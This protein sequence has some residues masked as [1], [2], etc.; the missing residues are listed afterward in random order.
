MKSIE[1]NEFGIADANKE[2]GDKVEVLKAGERFDETVGYLVF[3]DEEYGD[4][5][6]IWVFWDKDYQEGTSYF[7]SLKETEK[8]LKEELEEK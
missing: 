2:K 7:E 3:Q 5:K 4:K 8:S 6:N 1:F